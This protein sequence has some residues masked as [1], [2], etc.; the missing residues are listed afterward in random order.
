VGWLEGPWAKPTMLN[1]EG[2]EELDQE[3]LNDYTYNDERTIL[4]GRVR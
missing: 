3:R 2:D 1:A 4:Q